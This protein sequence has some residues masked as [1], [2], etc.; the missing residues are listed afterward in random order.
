L[1]YIFQ[2][3]QEEEK[4]I[5]FLGDRIKDFNLLGLLVGKIS[6]AKE[7][8]IQLRVDPYSNFSH[9][10]Q[11]VVYHDIVIILGNLIE[12]AFDSLREMSNIEKQVEVS[13]LQDESF[14]TIEVEDNG[15]GIS[16]EDQVRIFTKGFSTKGT[17]E[18]GIGLYL[19]SSI[20]NRSGGEIEVDSDLGHG[21][22]ITIRIPME[23]K[24]G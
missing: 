6:R 15:K 19:V 11:N 3:S 12:N 4:L 1:G 23:R 7:L 18:H 8:D 24:E 20:V 2:I 16:Q 22:R 14:L 17:A 5:H 9:F 10:P 13:I 21:T